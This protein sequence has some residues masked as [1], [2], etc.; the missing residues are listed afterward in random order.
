MVSETSVRGRLAPL[1]L[2]LIRQ[3]ITVGACDIE[4][5]CLLGQEGREGE[6]Y[7][8]LQQHAPNDKKLSLEAALLQGLTSSNS[9]ELRTKTLTSGP[10]GEIL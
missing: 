2:N 10:F 1:F 7:S 5:L 6:S 8:P 9:S 4:A 3:D